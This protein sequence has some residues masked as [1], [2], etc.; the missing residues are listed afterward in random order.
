MATTN[1]LQLKLTLDNGKNAYINLPQAKAGLSVSDL[2]GKFAPIT[3]AYAT[4]DGSTI[5]AIDVSTV[6]TS[7][8]VIAEN[9]N[10]NIEVPSGPDTPGE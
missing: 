6:R 9:W 7:T 10:D 8:T 2:P 1:K 4:D 5:T 3:A